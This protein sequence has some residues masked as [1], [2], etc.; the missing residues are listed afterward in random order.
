MTDIT[1][2][3]R[4][5]QAESVDRYGCKTTHVI[6][7]KRVIQIILRENKECNEIIIDTGSPNLFSPLNI[8]KEKVAIEEYR[9][10]ITAWINYKVATED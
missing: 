1:K 8:D 3:N 5:Y 10:I 6:D 7:L 2:P 9:K 4:F